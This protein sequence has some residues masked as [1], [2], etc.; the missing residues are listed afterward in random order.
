MTEPQNPE[1]Q[2]CSDPATQEMRIFCNSQLDDYFVGVKG[3]LGQVERLVDDTVYKSHRSY[4]GVAKAVTA[5]N[6][7]SREK[8]VGQQGMGAGDIGLF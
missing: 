4:E 3:E 7:V 6:A 2:T 8:P 5:A 1:M